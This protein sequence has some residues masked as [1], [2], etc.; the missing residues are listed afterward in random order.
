L[1]EDKGKVADWTFPGSAATALH[2]NTRTK[3]TGGGGVTLTHLA[4]LDILSRIAGE[5]RPSLLDLVGEGHGP[6]DHTSCSGDRDSIDPSFRGITGAR[7]R[8][9]N[10]CLRSRG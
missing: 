10:S 7:G 6:G 4:A 9:R 3:R 1:A 8:V 2:P 5:G